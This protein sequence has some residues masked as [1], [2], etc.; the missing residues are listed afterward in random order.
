MKSICRRRGSCRVCRNSARKPCSMFWL[1]ASLSPPRNCVVEFNSDRFACVTTT[2][3]RWAPPIVVTKMKPVSA[4]STKAIA[5]NG[6]Q[7]EDERALRDQHHHRYGHPQQQVRRRADTLDVAAH[8]MRDARVTQTR[9]LIP[10]RG[11]E[12]RGDAQPLRLDEAG[13]QLGH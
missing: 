1:L 2:P 9:D 6:R 3:L 5:A 4:S 7:Q 13:L 8:E 12:R 10:R 11:G